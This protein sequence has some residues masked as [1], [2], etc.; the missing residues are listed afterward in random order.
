VTDWEG[1]ERA[2]ARAHDLLAANPP[3][4]PR[5]LADLHLA[6]GNLY[7]AIGDAHRASVDYRSAR[8]ASA[9]ARDV[10]GEAMALGNLAIL[11]AEEGEPEKALAGLLEMRDTVPRGPGADGLLAAQ[12]EG[13]LAEALLRVGKTSEAVV[14]ARRA[15]EGAE[16]LGAEDLAANVRDT[17]ADAD[18]AQGRPAEAVANYQAVLDAAQRLQ[19]DDLRLQGWSGIARAELLAKRPLQAARAAREAVAALD[20]LTRHAPPGA[21]VDL[22]ARRAEAYES[23]VLA[24]LALENAGELSFF[25]EA[26]RCAEL[27]SA[28]GGR[29]GAE[30]LA[31]SEEA[32]AR[33]AQARARAQATLTRL[34]EETAGGVRGSA[35]RQALRRR[36]HD[37]ALR[38]V[39]EAERALDGEARAGALRDALRP[40]IESVADLQRDL[41]EDEAFVAYG[42]AGTLACALVVTRSAANPVDLGPREGVDGAV[43]GL[44]V[45]SGRPVD[46]EAVKRL[47]D[48]IVKPLALP[49]SVR[50]IQVSP[51][52]SLC[53]APFPLLLPPEVAVTFVPSATTRRM[54]LE[55]GRRRGQGV[56]AVGDPDVSGP[57]PPPVLSSLA[58]AAKRLERLPGAAREARLLG[59]LVIVGPLATEQ[60]LRDALKFV[61]RW[62]TV[63]LGCH[64]LVDAR[65]P[66]AS[67]LA[68]APGGGDDGWLTGYEILR[69]E[70]P[71]D[72]VVL[73]ACESGAGSYV[74]GEGLVGLTRAVMFAGAPRVVVSLWKADDDSTP[75]LMK[76]LH[77]RWKDGVSASAALRD[78]QNAVREA[79]PEW[80]HPAHWAGWQLWGLAD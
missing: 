7:A 59:D 48:R 33:L 46:A 60:A 71:A 16:A 36:E 77:A 15:L 70:V 31:L 64:G 27:L 38:E 3:E 29:D 21:V 5:D 42:L 39:L 22:R 40:R 35:E 32:V 1:A 58:A 61:P 8:A 67:V 79:R 69:M 17:L 80:D 25:L 50:R 6:R 54:L 74:A 9:A 43:E 62:R 72:L 12:L 37:T 45:R 11:A 13:N 44:V 26:G 30:R 76:E 20:A 73:S 78:A 4:D 2:L 49:A 28:L 47:H 14:L 55:G 63:H 18:V 66:L 57:R 52:G 68:L 23:G 10:A 56:L 19:S 53:A 51:D 34:V 65:S 41:A 75:V 24:A